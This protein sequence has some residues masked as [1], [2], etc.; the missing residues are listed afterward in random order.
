MDGKQDRTRLAF[1]ISGDLLTLALLTIIGFAGHRTLTT[2]G[3]RMLLTFIPLVLGWFAIAPFIGAY[4]IEYL[5]SPVQI[6]RPI[7]AMLVCMPFAAWLRGIGL[8]SPIQPVFVLVLGGTAAFAILIWRILYYM[9][10]IRR[11]T[12]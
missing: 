5:N 8:R 7:W 4:N 9:L 10:A 6:W 11:K 2:A 3:F 12:S 1:L